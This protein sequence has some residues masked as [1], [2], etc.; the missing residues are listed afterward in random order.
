[1]RGLGFITN[2]LVIIA[3][4]NGWICGTPSQR[5]LKN[6]LSPF[7]IDEMVFYLVGGAVRDRDDGSPPCHGHGSG[8]RK[9]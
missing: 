2:P 5:I 1:M 6:W 3:F 4:Q 9:R 7:K 8:L